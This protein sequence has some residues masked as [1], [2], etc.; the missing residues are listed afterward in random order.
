MLEIAA[1]LLCLV[2][3][4]VRLSVLITV[5]Q[6]NN[7]YYRLKEEDPALKTEF[8]LDYTL[9]SLQFDTCMG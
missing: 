1:L 8:G 7:K 4:A 9:R 3:V 2:H 5:K 6:C